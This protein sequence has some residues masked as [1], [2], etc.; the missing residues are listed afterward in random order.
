MVSTTLHDVSI[1]R[2][3]GF[4]S[5]MATLT[6]AGGPDDGFYISRQVWQY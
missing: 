5:A 3:V 1:D 6:G 2:G 4:V